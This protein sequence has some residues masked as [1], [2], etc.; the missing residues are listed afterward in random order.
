MRDN[1]F[2]RNAA[3]DGRTHQQ[4][5]DRWMGVN[6]TRVTSSHSSSHWVEGELAQR[7][8]QEIIDSILANELTHYFVMNPTYYYIGIGFGIQSN[9]RV[10]LSITM[11]S[12]PNERVYHRSRTT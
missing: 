2:G 3:S 7:H 10:R 11:V 1:D 4:R 12:L 8:V 5:H 6:R 9:G